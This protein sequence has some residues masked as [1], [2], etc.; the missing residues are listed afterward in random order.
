MQ[1]DILL[2]KVNKLHEPVKQYL[3][4]ESVPKTCVLNSTSKKYALGEYQALLDNLKNFPTIHS[5]RDTSLRKIFQVFKTWK[6]FSRVNGTAN[7]SHGWLYFQ[8]TLWHSK[9][10]ISLPTQFD[11]EAGYLL[12]GELVS[13]DNQNSL[14]I[15]QDGQGGWIVTEFS[16]IDGGKTHLVET[17]RLLGEFEKVGDLKYRVYWSFDSENNMY[18]QTAARFYG[19]D[20]AEKSQ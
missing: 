12:Y 15:R 13:E 20:K 1:A 17:I 3:E 19:F 10:D 9:S 2:E 7:F 18:R 8:H 5:N 11:K 6:V 14:H 4:L 16:E